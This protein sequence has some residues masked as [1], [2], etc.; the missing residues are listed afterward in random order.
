MNK[1]SR[2]LILE[3]YN[4]PEAKLKD[5]YEVNIEA[6]MDQKVGEMTATM[7]SALRR[8]SLINFS[9][10]KTGTGVTVRIKKSGGRKLFKGA[11]IA[12]SSSSQGG[13]AEPQVFIR[14]NVLKPGTQMRRRP[15]PSGPELPIQKLTTLRVSGIV[16]KQADELIDQ[17]AKVW[18]KEFEKAWNSELRKLGYS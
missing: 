2:E 8:M 5:A 17:A 14:K 3:R 13:G 9:A 11:F 16:N 18:Q 4:V 1:K 7:G 15:A 10:S 6:K 12:K